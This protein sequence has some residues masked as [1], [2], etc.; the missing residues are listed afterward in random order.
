[1]E[2]EK[3]EA[4]LSDYEQGLSMLKMSEK[5]GISRQQIWAIAK[6]NGCKPRRT[7]EMVICPCCGEE[8]KRQ[9]KSSRIYCSQ[10]CYIKHQL[11]NKDSFY[12]IKARKLSHT[13]RTFQRR[14]RQVASSVMKL[15]KAWVVHHM[16]GDITNTEASNLFVFYSHS[17]HLAYHHRLK[18]DKRS[19][20][21]ASDGFYV[22]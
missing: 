9:G 12:G 3:K 7:I 15:D 18:Q 21:K 2:I 11:G 19:K 8:F 10:R 1:M 4:I 13:T 22:V 6:D 16:D 5:H 17:L 14:S 20:P